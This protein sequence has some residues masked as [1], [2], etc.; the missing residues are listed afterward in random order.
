MTALVRFCA[1]AER[2]ALDRR[3]RFPNIRQ[4][5]FGSVCASSWLETE[6]WD[7]LERNGFECKKNS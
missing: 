1:E 3:R 2:F 5:F 7:L 4:S 6:K